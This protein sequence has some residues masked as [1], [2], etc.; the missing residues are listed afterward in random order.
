MF[1]ILN[2][3]SNEWNYYLNKILL[4]KQDIYYT[5]SYYKMHEKNGDGSGRLVVYTDNEKIALYPFV[6]NEIN[7]YDLD[8]KYYDI[9]SAYGYGGP[10]TN[11]HHEVFLNKFENRFLEY[12]KRN[13]IVAEFIR[14][15]PLI[16]DE[17][18]FNKNINIS[19]N[20]ST[21]YLDLTKGLDK[22]WNEEIKSKNRNMIRKAQRSGLIVEESNDYESFR[23]IYHE[24]MDK[25]K[26]SDYYY[27]NE[28]YYEELKANNNYILLNVKLGEL[29]IASAIFIKYKEYFHYHLAGSLQGYLKFAPNNLLLWEA[30]KLAYDS[31]AKWFHF[32]GGLSNNLNDNLF[33]FKKSFS[34]DTAEFYIGKRIHN[35]EVYDY[36][37]SEW[38]KKNVL[39]AKLFLQYKY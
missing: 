16:K 37:I 22:I 8:K 35:K 34:R 5:S 14:F 15:H 24:T 21:V 29:N 1:K 39:K 4:E 31:G 11:S 20:R 27:F 3:Q 33:K 36:L 38:E 7:G 18:I 25:V 13:N 9:E 17:R 30:I 28:D 12:C 19:Y 10:V 6:M 23:S 2:T 32:G 26:A